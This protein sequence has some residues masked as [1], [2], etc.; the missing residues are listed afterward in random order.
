MLQLIH[1]KEHNFKIPFYGQRFKK[2]HP[3][4]RY[5]VKLRCDSIQITSQLARNVYFPK[6]NNRN[7]VKYH[8]AEVIKNRSQRPLKLYF[9]EVMM[10]PH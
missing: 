8:L 1:D 10:D 6:M 3:S 7:N 2:N 9:G 5:M 4:N